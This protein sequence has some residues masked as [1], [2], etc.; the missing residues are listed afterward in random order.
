MMISVNLITEFNFAST[1]IHGSW[2]VL[3]LSGIVLR[4]RKATKASPQGQ[5]QTSKRRQYNVWF[6]FVSYFVTVVA[7]AVAPGPIVLMMM[8]R[9]ASSDVTSAAGFAFGSAV[10]GVLII[11][12]VCFGLGNWLSAV[13]EVFEYSKFAM[14]AYI[15]G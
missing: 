3:G 5:P 11:S 13:P 1:L 8:V 15:F 12:V 10:G 7:L 4:V 6:R 14:M 2:I 9:S